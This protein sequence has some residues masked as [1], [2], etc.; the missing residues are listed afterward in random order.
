MHVFLM[1]CLNVFHGNGFFTSY[2]PLGIHIALRLICI[3]DMLFILYHVLS[4]IAYVDVN[5]IKTIYR[6]DITEKF[7]KVALN[8]VTPPPI[9]R[10]KGDNILDL[11]RQRWAVVAFID[12]AWRYQRGNQNPYIEEEQTTQ[13]P[14]KKYKKTNNDLQNIHIK[15]KIE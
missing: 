13:W 7:L 8:T 11:R 15:L 3:S 10:I 2:R 5:S 1:Y 14:K 9:Y 12:R 6:H 4:N